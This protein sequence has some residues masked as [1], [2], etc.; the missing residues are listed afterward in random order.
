MNN[1]EPSPIWQAHS[2]LPP[3]YHM[4]GTPTKA[5]SMNPAFV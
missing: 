5:G 4:P 1:L 2:G 3:S